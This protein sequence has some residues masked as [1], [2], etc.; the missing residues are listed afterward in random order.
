[1][2]SAGED[3]PGKPQ[4]SEGA[5]AHDVQARDIGR[6]LSIQVPV[7]AVLAKKRMKLAEVLKLSVGS[8]VQLDK[9]ADD[10]LELMVNDQRLGRGETV[11]IGEN[12]GLQ[13]VEIGSLRQT[14]RKLGGEAI[15]EEQAQPAKGGEAGK[16]E[17]DEGDSSV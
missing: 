7:I 8:I 3:A 2:S 11:R 12:F 5:P 15:P 1:M 10:L 13:L 14:I 4:G 9:P 6:L 16:A 17:A